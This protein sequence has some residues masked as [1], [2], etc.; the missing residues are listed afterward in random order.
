[1][2]NIKNLEEKKRIIVLYKCLH[3][4]YP[5]DILYNSR[6]YEVWLRMW[7]RDFIVNGKRLKMWH[8]KF[9]ETVGNINVMKNRQPIMLNIM[10]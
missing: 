8:Q 3:N 1:M 2:I 6:I 10:I 5:Q 7:K 4:K 9:V